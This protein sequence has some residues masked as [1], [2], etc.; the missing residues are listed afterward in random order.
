MQMGVAS[1]AL[2]SPHAKT[3]LLFLAHFYKLPLPITDY[4]ND[5]KSVLEQFNRLVGSLMEVIVH[6][7]APM[8]VSEM[9]TSKWLATAVP[10]SRVLAALATLSAMAAHGEPYRPVSKRPVGKVT[11][12]KVSRTGTEGVKLAL[13]LSSA[14][15]KAQVSSRGSLKNQADSSAWIFVAQLD[16]SSG[17]EVISAAKKLEMSDMHSGQR[18]VGVKTLTAAEGVC[19][20]WLFD[21]GDQ[22]LA[23]TGLVESK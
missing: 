21:T 10:P 12:D 11:L 14:H 22:S 19:S 16:F 7:S 23:V 3:F 8:G 18:A 4:V 1:Q 2:D 6:L 20:V 5:T 17:R 13:T 9:E 15:E